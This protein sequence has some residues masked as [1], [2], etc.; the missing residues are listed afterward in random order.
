MSEN[1]ISRFSAPEKAGKSPIRRLE[2]GNPSNGKNAAHIL[3]NMTA[4]SP[5]PCWLYYLADPRTPRH[6]RYV[7]IT[8]NPE[9]RLKRHRSLGT[10]N[11]D[12]QQWKRVMRADGVLPTLFLMAVFPS[13]EVARDVE[14]RTIHRWR[15]RGL[16]DC[17]TARD[18]RSTAWGIQMDARHSRSR[19]AIA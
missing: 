16:C 10:Y 13:V 17:N 2:S 3:A 12:L 9:T 15:R 14:W 6:P 1:G 7:G 19:Q 4:T 11:D 8:I 5:T 18:G